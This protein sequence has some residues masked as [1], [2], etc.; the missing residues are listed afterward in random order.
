M[1]SIGVTRRIDCNGRLALPTEVRNILSLNGGDTVEF[2]YTTDGEVILRK[3][4]TTS[5]LEETV[6]SLQFLLDENR[7]TLPPEL[8]DTLRSHVSAV[9]KLLSS[10]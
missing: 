3:L 4:N 1:K 7:T 5:R 6:H 10:L 9:E 2:L 8:H